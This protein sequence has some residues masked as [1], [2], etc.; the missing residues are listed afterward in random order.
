MLFEVN[1]IMMEDTK[2]NSND[3]DKE[4]NKDKDG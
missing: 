2:Q 1:K 3:K 4:G